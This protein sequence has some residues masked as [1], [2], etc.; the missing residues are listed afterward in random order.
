MI[1]KF[2]HT[3][4]WWPSLALALIQIGLTL[5]ALSQPLDSYGQQNAWDVFLPQL[6][7][8]RTLALVT[9]LWWTLLL[10]R[11]IPTVVSPERLIRLGSVLR[12]V[13]YSL[14]QLLPSLLAGLL[15]VSASTY[16]VA[17]AKSN[18]LYWSESAHLLHDLRHEIQLSVFSPGALVA[19]FE[20]PFTALIAILAWC[21]TGYLLVAALCIAVAVRFGRVTAA[22]LL[23]TAFSAMAITT[24]AGSMDSFL[25]V[26]LVSLPWA[27]G[28]ETFTTSIVVFF[29]HTC[30]NCADIN[31]LS[32]C[33]SE[34]RPSTFLSSHIRPSFTC[35]R[36]T[37]S[38]FI[39]NQ[40][41]R[42]C[43]Q[44]SRKK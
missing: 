14:V 16:C 41:I 6:S 2:W 8:T 24:F 9:F 21:A 42:H 35:N 1:T 15:L 23:W 27:I 28:T 40:R 19:H 10:A 18:S 22:V 37:I 3:I 5:Y 4:T 17:S 38:P 20:S 44:I 11:Q 32:E 43:R 25:P 36:H 30:A 13:T 33:N 12:S 26:S 31:V 7:E 39:P 29:L 34:L